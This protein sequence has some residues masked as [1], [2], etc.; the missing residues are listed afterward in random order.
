MWPR[1]ILHCDIN[2]CYAQ[3]E[4]MKFPELKHVPMAVG[5]SE[6]SRNGII[7][8]RNLKAKQFDVATAETLREALNKCNDLVIVSP[9]YDDYMYYTEKVKDIYRDYSDQVE[10]FGLDEAWVDITASQSL[11]GDPISIAK[12]IQQRV[13]QE[14]G[15]TI[16][17]GLSFNKIFAK[18]GSDLIKPSGFVVITK[19]NVQQLVH[20]LPV[21]NLMYVG[22][23]T[24]KILY[25]RG[26]TTIGDIVSLPIDYLKRILGKN[27]EMIYHF[28]QGNDVSDV[29]T[30]NFKRDVKSIGNSITA[31]KDIKNHH[32]AMLVFT[33]LCQA[34]ASRLKDSGFQ[35]SLVRISL[36]N[37]QLETIQR[38]MPLEFPTN[39]SS[40]LI[41][42]VHQ[43]LSSNYTFSIPLRSVGVSVS[44][45]TP[46]TMIQYNLFIDEEQ[47]LT[48][49]KIDCV[50]DTIKN[51]YGFNSIVT[52]SSLLDRQLTDFDPK[53]DHIIFPVSFL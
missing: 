26:I 28:A 35:G 45:L 36:R 19:D 41:S 9:N 32:E 33:I 39:I 12:T 21:E 50:M 4:E 6:A 5:G 15:L 47:R 7:L 18:L 17:I 1:A 16:S 40:E 51:K 8:A 25:S 29:T 42:T 43:L 53:G 10:S 24:K 13:L 14:V 49:K 3:I 37:N 31:V 11:F 52:C 20:P 22:K 48:N 23:A 38:Q 46:D 2:H 30:S 27:G 44:K 34:V